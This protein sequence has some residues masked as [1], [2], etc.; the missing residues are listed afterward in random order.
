MKKYLL[1]LFFLKCFVVEGQVMFQKTYGTGME[2]YFLTHQTSD[3]GYIL[4]GYSAGF[5]LGY[6]SDIYLVKINSVGDTLWTAVF[7][8]ES[9]GTLWYGCNETNDHGFVVTWETFDSTVNAHVACIM[10]IDSLGS[11]VWS[12]SYRCLQSAFLNT[13]YPST[14]KQTADGGYIITGT[15]NLGFSQDFDII[16]MKTDSTGNVE[17]CQSF[18]AP[19]HDGGIDV[20]EVQGGYVI[21]GVTDLQ[22]N[23]SARCLIK[24]DLL[25]NLLWSRHYGGNGV[26]PAY[27]ISFDRTAD[28]G[29]ILIGGD[30]S[31]VITK[32]DSMGLPI[33]SVNY[34]NYDGSSYA[35]SVKSTNDGG[36]LIA[37]TEQDSL[38][39][40]MLLLKIDSVGGIIF[41]KVYGPNYGPSYGT[42]G[43]YAEQTAD[44]GYIICG[45]LDTVMDYRSFLVKTDANGNSG[46]EEA[47]YA[48]NVTNFV[49]Q[50]YIPPFIAYTGQMTSSTRAIRSARGGSIKTRC[51]S[52][53]TSKT[54]GE[55]Q[56]I[57]I[58]PNPFHTS[59]TLTTS[60][61]PDSYR[62]A[63]GN[64]QLNIYSTMG[65]LVRSEGISN[66]SSYSLHRG[67]L[68]EGLYFYE[69]RS[70]NYELIGTGKFIIE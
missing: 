59:A 43:G 68:C 39:W 8:R 69:L 50:S 13:F 34:W 41:E 6:V 19:N 63:A 32:T 42:D 58:S 61:H 20:I 7:E 23:P 38:G 60:W 12:Q 21:Y 29:F 52:V 37:G 24:T 62:D 49:T 56:A 28:G 40:K 17:W 67:E 36:Y 46:C 18:V 55:N 9:T 27:G 53:G 22:F 16:L 35:N 57:T 64:L 3:G 70:N 44:G 26:P 10:K 45:T 25:G 51:I 31:I 66:L 11:E 4:Y 54:E 1:F 5:G 14:A 48:F 47:T 15:G 2:E 65:T 33:W 30:A